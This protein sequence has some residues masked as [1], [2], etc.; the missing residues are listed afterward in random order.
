[1]KEDLSVAIA[2]HRNGQLS[3]AEKIYLNLLKENKNNV[4]IL[5]LLGTIYLQI[6]HYELSEKYFLKCLEKDPKNPSA[7][8]NLGILKKNTNN[9]EKSIEYFEIN[10]KKNNFLNSWINKSNILLENKKYTEGLEFSKEGL[11][12]YPND[13][14]LR[15]NFGIFLFECGYQNEALNV[16]QQFDDEGIHFIDSYFNYSNILIKIN[17]YSKSL[18]ILNKLLLLDQKNLNALR[19]RAFIYKQFSDFKKAEEDLKLSIK[20]EDSNFLNNKSIVDL[21]IDTKE[22]LKAIPY[23]EKMIK[24]TLKNSFFYTKKYFQNYT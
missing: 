20:I 11:L 23:C 15:N 18:S 6:K 21:Y 22:Y 8:N 10:I 1:M 3:K 9:I 24:K 2:L 17:N 19:Q 13:I 7:L 16:Y 12:K 4:P 5:Q 14:K